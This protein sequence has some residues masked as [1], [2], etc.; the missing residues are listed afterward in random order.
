MS[1]DE[2]LSLPL[3]H[4][5]HRRNVPSLLEITGIRPG[6]GRRY[7]EGLYFWENSS[8]LADRWA[9]REN[10]KK[11]AVV[12]TRLQVESGDIVDFLCPEAKNRFEDVITTWLE[13]VSTRL[14]IASILNDYAN[15]P[16]GLVSYSA[17]GYLY[18]TFFKLAS[19]AANRE[20]L[21]YRLV[22]LE[23]YKYRE[24]CGF[25]N[26]M[27]DDV[28]TLGS[29]FSAST[30][31]WKEAQKKFRIDSDYASSHAYVLVWV[32]RDLAAIGP[33]TEIEVSK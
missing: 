4:A 18:D 25:D 24:R 2:S 10:K 31:T 13:N 17:S 5:T 33:M 6:R 30:A 1:F 29:M 28:K 8:R 32:V 7:G 19:R 12:A 21:A 26:A 9:V 22:I 27:K 23:P 16:Q 20:Y 3:F 15:N 14:D 11:G